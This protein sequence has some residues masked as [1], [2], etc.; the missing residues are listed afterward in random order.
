MI[1]WFYDFT[2]KKPAWSNKEY[3]NGIAHKWKKKVQTNAAEAPSASGMLQSHI[4]VL[5]YNT[6]FK[7]I[8]LSFV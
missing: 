1:L 8:Y 2:Y 3:L 4:Y 7:H 6:A 5:D